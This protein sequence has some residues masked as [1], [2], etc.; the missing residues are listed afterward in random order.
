MP[1]VEFHTRRQNPKSPS[2]LLARARALGGGGT[3]EWETEWIKWC[4]EH[5]SAWEPSGNGDK[6]EKP[7]AAYLPRRHGSP[8]SASAQ[9]CLSSMVWNITRRIQQ[10]FPTQ[11]D[12][13]FV[14]DP[15]YCSSQMDTRGQLLNTNVHYYYLLLFC[16]RYRVYSTSKSTSDIH[17]SSQGRLIVDKYGVYPKTTH[18]IS[19]HNPSRACR[20]ASRHPYNLDLNAYTSLPPL[21]I[22]INCPIR[23]ARSLTP[24]VS[25]STV[26]VS[27]ETNTWHI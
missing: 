16:T 19:K 24:P 9:F 15:S 27:S 14:V 12:Q 22:M 10:S 25:G 26:L 17:P 21:Q 3:A 11:A 13:L 6:M 4:V 20:T 5:L 1:L 7:S 2:R 18:V 23:K 8:L